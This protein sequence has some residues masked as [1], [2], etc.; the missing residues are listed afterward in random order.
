[1][2]RLTTLFGRSS[3]AARRAITLRRHMS[4][5]R[6]LPR[7]HAQ[8]ARE[9]GAVG[10]GEGLLVVAPAS[11]TTTQSTRTPGILTWRELSVPR[12]AMRSTC[13]ITSPPLLRA[14]IAID[15]LSSVS[16]SRSI[17]MLP[18]ASAVV[19]RTIAT[20]IGKRLVEEVFLAADRHQR[21]QLVDAAGVELAAAV[22]RVDEGAEADPAQVPGLA[23]GD[24]AEQ[25]RDHA[26]RQVVGLDL[27][28]DRELLQLRHQA[29]VA[30]DRALH[31]SRR[32]P[33]G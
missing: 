19:P 9:G 10:G 2:P 17:V 14:A 30:A 23:A 33:G 15:R 27:V 11:A 26:L 5:G 22:A 4:N 16:A 7:R 20:S 21:H 12:S 1:M 18:S 6:S 8:L 24:V 3:S 31:Q 29:P 28:V 25:V 32:A 13:T